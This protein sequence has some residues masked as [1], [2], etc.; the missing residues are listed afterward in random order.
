MKNDSNT[1][2]SAWLKT[3]GST[4]LAQRDQKLTDFAVETQN[5]KY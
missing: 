4:D 5:S 2:L 3:A 1:G